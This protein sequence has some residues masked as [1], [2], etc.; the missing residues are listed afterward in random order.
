MNW[1]QAHEAGIFPFAAGNGKKAKENDDNQN[2]F[3]QCISA[4]PEWQIQTLEG[5]HVPAWQ[6]EWIEM[7]GPSTKD[8]IFISNQTINGMRWIM[9]LEPESMFSLARYPEFEY[10]RYQYPIL[11][12]TSR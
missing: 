12:V 5:M 8:Y 6:P 7:K 9:A 11:R 1:V 3:L 4:M 2:T 10:L